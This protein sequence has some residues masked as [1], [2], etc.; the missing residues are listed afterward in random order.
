[1]AG[2]EKCASSVSRPNDLMAR[3]KAG[4]LSPSAAQD[5]HSVSGKDEHARMKCRRFASES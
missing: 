3:T 2:P 5:S 4:E 1:M